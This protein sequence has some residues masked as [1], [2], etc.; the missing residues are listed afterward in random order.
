MSA[1]PHT[2]NHFIG[3]KKQGN[4]NYQIWE[5]R[6][7]QQVPCLIGAWSWVVCILH[8][9]SNR[10]EVFQIWVKQR[11][12]PLSIQYGRRKD[13]CVYLKMT[14]NSKLGRWG[15]YI[16]HRIDEASHWFDWAA[17][18]TWRRGGQEYHGTMA[19]KVQVNMCCCMQSFGQG[20][21]DLLRLDAGSS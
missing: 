1:M 10:E 9:K 5:I 18:I 15:T 11:C 20:E 13:F 16:R 14:K 17:R 21:G 8:F 19:Q 12:H 3:K 7:A 4:S 2:T 6:L